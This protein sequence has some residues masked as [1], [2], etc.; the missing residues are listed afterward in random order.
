MSTTIGTFVDEKDTNLVLYVERS[1]AGNKLF[2]FDTKKET[3]LKFWIRDEDLEALTEAID[4][5]LFEALRG[6]E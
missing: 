1:C 3:G 6:T 4:I 2:I 5:L